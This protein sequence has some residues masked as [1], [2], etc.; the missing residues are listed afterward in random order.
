ME[1][2]RA[3]DAAAAEDAQDSKSDLGKGGIELGRQ[4]TAIEVEEAPV[5]AFGDDNDSADADDGT[6]APAK[7]MTFA[8]Q[9]A[10]LQDEVETESRKENKMKE[11]IE[12]EGQ[13]EAKKNGQKLSREDTKEVHKSRH[14][15]PPEV[16]MHRQ[17][18]KMQKARDELIEE[19]F[20]D[21]YMSTY[22]LH[23]WARLFV[24]VGIAFLNFWIL[25]EDP[26]AH[27]VV[28]ANVII[29]GQV[30]ALVCTRWQGDAVVGKAICAVLGILIGCVFG[31][32][33]LQQRCLR[34][35]CSMFKNDQGSMMVMLWSS[36]IALYGF[37]WVFNM[38][39][40]EK[41]PQTLSDNMGITNETFSKIAGTCCWMGDF[42]TMFLV[43]D[44]MLQDHSRFRAWAPCCRK[45]WKG[46]ARIVI[47]WVSVPI[48]VSLVAFIVA[49][50]YARDG[51][52]EWDKAGILPSSEL[53][54]SFVCGIITVFDIL[55]VVQDWDFPEF[56]GHIDIKF[57]GMSHSSCTCSI[58][59]C[60]PCLKK[61]DASSLRGGELG[62][63]V[64]PADDTGGAAAVEAAS[65]QGA[66]K[67][68]KKAYY[69]AHGG[70]PCKTPG[71][72]W[73]A[74]AGSDFCTK[75]ECRVPWHEITVTGKWFN[76][77]IIFMVM[78]F[79]GNMIKNQIIYQP[80]DFAQYTNPGPYDITVQYMKPDGT[81]TRTQWTFDDE[82]SLKGQ[83]WTVFDET[84]LD[85]WKISKEPSFD[86]LY[87]GIDATVNGPRNAVPQTESNSRAH[88]NFTS[89]LTS[90]NQS[91]TIL[92]AFHKQHHEHERVYWRDKFCPRKQC[93][94]QHVKTFCTLPRCDE[95]R[96]IKDARYCINSTS[97][98]ASRRH[99][100]DS[101]SEVPP[102]NVCTDEIAIWVMRKIFRG[103]NTSLDYPDLPMNSRYEYHNRSVRMIALVP[104][105]VCVG[106]VVFLFS[107][108]AKKKLA[109]HL[110][111]NIMA[112]KHT[113]HTLADK[114][115]HH[116][117]LA[118]GG[119]AHAHEKHGIGHTART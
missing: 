64:V 39:I 77:G 51:K 80:R 78:L 4:P 32:K 79:D 10:L 2:L 97:D 65:R 59:K 23:P 3:A 43:I 75:P 106:L 66:Q 24:A 14:E 81:P 104:L 16:I 99:L 82:S 42:L 9:R 115:H 112:A 100:D 105:V 18:A 35:R 57:P 68:K 114:L 55:I 113:A 92:N 26:I 93:D 31:K 85:L 38:I 118:A 21:Q 15:E 33:V 30:F 47:F 74:P 37:S 28:E 34:G 60:F 13:I 70:Q 53:T 62:T 56:D 52:S 73:V 109:K 69:M 71:C 19:N 108:H 116:H 91:V 119:A 86:L 12:R 72:K 110:M 40:D 22:F 98:D 101:D 58:E 29:I 48:G 111:T 102:A 7:R 117:L 17:L 103:E 61:K 90:S 41:H 50:D 44:G 5:R 95:A 49:Q 96:N 89:P 25:L 67:R 36:L 88:V 54:R 87:V 46:T 84:A 1:T 8:Q 11:E 63:A 6:F 27:S 107:Q 83:I 45:I 94:G 76:Y 20:I